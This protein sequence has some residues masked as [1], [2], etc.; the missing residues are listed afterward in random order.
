MV[1]WSSSSRKL[2][3]DVDGGRACN[4]MVW[5]VCVGL[6]WTDKVPLMVRMKVWWV[7]SALGRGVVGFVEWWVAV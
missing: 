6:V 3:W 7:G 2:V 4:V 5:K 1:L